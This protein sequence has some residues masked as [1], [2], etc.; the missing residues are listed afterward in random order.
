MAKNRY[1]RALKVLKNSQVDEKL[2]MLESL[3]TNNTTG[4]YV[5]E[6]A[7]VNTVTVPGEVDREADFTQDG[8]G[9]GSYDG[10]DTTGL[11]LSD[12]TIL[13]IEPPGDT[14]YIL[15]PMAS[16]WYAWGNFTQIG[17]IRQSDRKM[18][19]LAR[20]TGE[21]GSWDGSS[22]FTS[23]GQL[24][25]EQ[26]VW[27][28][29]TPK[30]NGA[31]N[32]TPN[33]RAFYPGPPSNVAD[34]HGRYLCV[35][36]GTTK[37]TSS[38]E[39]QRTPD[40]M[41]DA[42]SQGYPWEKKKLDDEDKN[43]ELMQLVLNAAMLGL[44]IA[45]VVALLFPEPGS[46]A[47]GAAYL[48][49]K[50]RY[51]AAFGRQLARLN[52]F[53]GSTGLARGLRGSRVGA[54]GLKQQ[55][56]QALKGGQNLH[57]G[58]KGLL[59]PG[60][61]GVYSAPRV[62]Q[63]GPGGLRPGSGAARYTQAGSNPLGG[64]A[65]RSGQ[66]GGV[67]GSIT[68]GG[69]RRIPG[70]PEPQSVVN[71]QTFQKGQRLFQKIQSGAY[72][73]S[74]RAN[75]LRRQAGQ[76]GFGPGQTSVPARK[77][78]RLENYEYILEQMN[79]C[80][81]FE[82]TGA[83]NVSGTE[84]A[85]GYVG[86]V[87]QNSSPEELEKASN[88]A[89]NIAK[90]GGQGVSEDE[91]AKIDQEVEGAINGLVDTID[92]TRPESMSNDALFDSVALMYEADENFFSE[93]SEKHRN[94]VDTK[95]ID[96]AYK[97]YS[98]RREYINSWENSFAISPEFESYYKGY[99]SYW[100]NFVGDV[101]TVPANDALGFSWRYKGREITSTEHDMI[102]SWSDLFTKAWDT[103]NDVVV[104]KKREQRQ[105]A[106]EEYEK[107]SGDAYRKF[108]IAIIKDW[109]ID[110]FALDEPV[111][112]DLMGDLALLGISAGAA[113]VLIKTLGAAKVAVL[114]KTSNG[115]RR[116]LR[117]WNKGR[118][119]T[120]PG[121][122][123]ASWKDLR[124]DDLAQGAKFVDPK[125]GELVGGAL[126]RN[127]QQLG[128]LLRG[129]G[130]FTWEFNPFPGGGLRTGPTALTRQLI[131][132]PFRA[133][134]K[135]FEDSDLKGNLLTEETSDEKALYDALDT[136][137]KETDP[138]D[139]GKVM[140]KFLAM[141]DD[142]VSKKKAM[143]SY[144]PK[145][146]QQR[147]RQPLEESITPKQKRILR[148]IKKPFEIKEAPTKFKVKP[149]G[150]N[151][152]VVGAGLMKPIQDPKAFKPDPAIWKA[153]HKKYNEAS[154]Q[155]KKNHVLELVGASDHHWS[156]LIERSGRERQEKVNEAMAKEFDREMERLYEKY[157]EKETKVDRVIQSIKTTSLDKSNIKPVHPDEPPSHTPNGYHA[158]Y[159]QKYKHDKL[160][161]HS[162]EFMPRTGNPVIDANI[163][164]AT[165]HKNKN[166]KTKILNKSSKI[167]RNEEYSLMK[168]LLLL[169]ND[170]N[171]SKNIS[172]TFNPPNIP[173]LSEGMTT[174]GITQT[175]LAPSGD[176]DIVDTEA[177]FDTIF[178]SLN[179][180]VSGGEIVMA[181]TE[182]SIN[183]GTHTIYRRTMLKVDATESST[184]LLTIQKG[185]GT[186]SWTDRGGA[187]SFDDGVNLNVYSESAPFDAPAYY[188]ADMDSGAYVIP[189]PKN[190]SDLVIQ[191][192]QFAKVGATGSLRI[193]RASLQR[194]TPVSVFVS[195]DD[196]EATSFINMGDMTGLSA[197][198]R[199]KRLLEML[200][201]GDEYV[202]KYIGP[203][204]PGTGVRPG[205]DSYLDI[206]AGGDQITMVD[207]ETVKDTIRFPGSDGDPSPPSPTPTP[208]P[209]TTTTT[210]T[211]TPTS[212]STTD[213]PS[214]TETT[215]KG[216]GAD[217]NKS[218]GGAE[219][220]RTSND[221]VLDM[222]AD[223]ENN[224]SSY[225]DREGVQT[226]IPAFDYS[227]DIAASIRSNTPVNIPQQN[228]PQGQIDKMI[229]SIDP[230]AISLHGDNFGINLV[231]TPQPYS[232]EH[233]YELPNGEVRAHTPE[234]REK[235]PNNT[236]GDASRNTG[237]AG[238]GNPLG[239][240]GNAQTQIVVPKDGSEPYLLYTD[241]AYVNSARMGGGELPDPVKGAIAVG[242]HASAGHGEAPKVGPGGVPIPNFELDTT[243][244]NTGKM[245]NYPPN[246]RGDVRKQ[247]RVPMNELPP[248]VREAIEKQR[249]YMKESANKKR[250]K[251][252]KDIPGYYDGKPAP[253]G[254]P[255]EKPPEMVDGKHPDLVT[256]KGQEKRSNRYNRLD[257]H[258][259]RAMPKTGNP[260]IDKKVKAAAKKPTKG[261]PHIN[262]KTT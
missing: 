183:G 239:A 74:T 46:S 32:D 242:V 41:G 95:T 255:M 101:Y 3:P 114:T 96:D 119:G 97:V 108:I 196:P 222:L 249:K 55:G 33:Y 218:G 60:G 73:K 8:D 1:T 181:G 40:V 103:F 66:P 59:S 211:S 30:L 56:F 120:V 160:D 204:F 169:S 237:F 109:Y 106:F 75:Q 34:E 85:D 20:I 188:Q 216:G 45:A 111:P 238:M 22:N 233:F 58:S 35:I 48:A 98:D 87:M 121:E 112:H 155:D 153:G 262:K 52:P 57:R 42:E 64:A 62:G 165:D 151:N 200:N 27:F 28:Q 180:T 225:E 11:F 236:R 88:D 79:N 224:P 195:L 71:P 148:E 134:K 143:E 2:Q 210:T 164:K 208:S 149:T 81:L 161:P 67:V 215:P 61:K 89:N 141:V 198:E 150:R 173:K 7:I 248:R 185:G 201:A 217:P 250:L 65:G 26:A 140:S 104:P 127:L 213:T 17:Y 192:E 125:T 246:I 100:D 219:S 51:A 170:H 91:L 175:T 223:I 260:F 110:P 243:T 240:A 117:W 78:P 191:I 19:N 247:I 193:T 172:N 9:G 99:Q 162:A 177:A 258:S 77:I 197:E 226:G 261:K 203:E 152:K 142:Q 107:V 227:A 138:K 199:R 179:S 259:A 244:P 38:E 83:G 230:Q 123:T 94:L 174:A 154:S 254:F 76:A 47:A 12:G 105:K 80:R 102:M 15:G 24:T 31:D 14:S 132:R 92:F 90:D 176:V 63:V 69:A 184:L 146:L 221:I 234:T 133:I 129:K 167:I 214:D 16:M 10:T 130:G 206:Q 202:E 182:N 93:L 53:R 4:L 50:L 39:E 82:Q 118:D 229:N 54:T 178:N 115:I 37:S 209:T 128:D 137:L 68:P 228:I 207:G 124:A 72:P 135:F 113:L 232:D 43:D 25:L 190:Y 18:V 147:S 205:E 145:F 122:N 126:P 13:T 158:K 251:S 44:D 86:E 49:P 171:K 84:A 189:I 21:L 166:R 159:G 235:Y 187:S 136:A 220:V 163:D 241:H 186:S 5:V 116:I 194:R 256:A 6:P 245:R 252:V 253:L 139:F 144:Q 168:K 23:Y 212:T 36:T 231:S 157:Q 156:T 131:E 70:G 29:G 257:P